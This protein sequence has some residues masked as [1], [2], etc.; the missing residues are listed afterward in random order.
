MG[1][2]VDSG[3]VE[4]KTEQE[5]E[6]F[7]HAGASEQQRDCLVKVRMVLCDRDGGKLSFPAFS[8]VF[9]KQKGSK[10]LHSL[11]RVSP[12]IDIKLSWYS[13]CYSYKQY[14]EQI[15]YLFRLSVRKKVEIL[16]KVHVLCLGS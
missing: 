9:L 3:G 11:L 4:R 15:L 5:D 1:D 6:W 7:Y 16:D 13:F 2:R 12:S 10:I 14:L 8:I